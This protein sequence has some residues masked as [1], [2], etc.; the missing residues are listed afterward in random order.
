MGDNSDDFEDFVENN[1]RMEGRSLYPIYVSVL[2]EK[3]LENS[4]GN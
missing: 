3:Q 2:E 4:N 1:R